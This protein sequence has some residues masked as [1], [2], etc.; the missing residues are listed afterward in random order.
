MDIVL[1]NGGEVPFYQ[2]IADQIKVQIMDGK[3]TSGEELP[4]IRLLANELHISVITTKRAYAEL[5]KVGFI[6]QVP[7]KGTFVADCSS[8]LIREEHI[9]A[10]ETDLMSC[11][12]RAHALGLSGE[13]ILFM[14]EVLLE[15]AKEGAHETSRH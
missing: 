9:R 1:D 14:T 8:N 5:A 13:E 6:T 12:S 11:F 3:L 2:Q 7:G 10:L 4:S 15:Q